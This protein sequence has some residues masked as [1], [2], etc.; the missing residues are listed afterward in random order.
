MIGSVV[1]TI[2]AQICIGLVS[3]VDN[4]YSLIGYLASA[5]IF[6][7]ASIKTFSTRIYTIIGIFMIFKLSFSILTYIVD[8]EKAQK[9]GGKFVM[10]IAISLGLIVLTPWLFAKA[11]QLQSAIL[12]DN[13]IGKIFLGIGTNATSMT[14][15]EN[16]PITY[17]LTYGVGSPFIY[18]ESTECQNAM[19]T[20]AEA[21]AQNCDSS[22]PFTKV[23][24]EKDITYYYDDSYLNLKTDGQYIIH[25]VGWGVLA[26]LSYIAVIIV[27]LGIALDV[28]VRTVKLGFLQIIAPVPIIM[29]MD[30]NKTGKDSMLGKWGT[31]CIN[32]YLDLFARLAALFFGIAVIQMIVQSGIT[33]AGGV[34]E[35]T[36]VIMKLFIIACLILGT[37]FFAKKLPDLIQKIL[38]IEFKGS[39][40]IKQG[41]PRMGRG[42]ALGAFG[43]A[44]GGIGGA[45][46]GIGR[47]IAGK[48]MKGGIEAQR[49]A[50]ARKRELKSNPDTGAFGRFRA[51]ANQMI[52]KPD[53]AA[54]DENTLKGFDRQIAD[55]DSQMGEYKRQK[56]AYESAKGYS[57]KIN[58]K[59]DKWLEGRVNDSNSSD[60]ANYYAA[61]DRYASASAALEKTPTNDAY[62][63][64]KATA[65][66]NT[67]ASEMNATKKAARIQMVNDRQNKL[68]AEIMGF[69]NI[70]SQNG[71]GVNITDGDSIYDSTSGVRTAITNNVN[72]LD[73]YI[74]PIEAQ[75]SSVELQKQQ[76]QTSD[77]YMKNKNDSQ[78]GKK[79]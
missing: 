72:T 59:V 32:T 51:R 66:K 58:D 28:A 73:S 52:G 70:S 77:K 9:T 39:L 8:P 21:V 17:T 4:I 54:R 68:Q 69:N 44:S 33:Y 19:V 15:S 42:L 10:N 27:L 40:G 49:K 2:F 65:A 47:G 43:L 16:V 71:L 13:T 24:D 61:Q 36:G 14:T 55:Y 22:G 57:D 23:Y 46:G 75:K 50:N 34:T 25:F 60:I 35:P 7:V 79:G 62:A 74:M 5:Q 56:S 48:D 3:L 18:P 53:A 63:M 41:I 30:P 11:F 78:Y 38:G 45:L 12:E 76:Y 67:A 37:L 1:R 31:E 6:D 29:Y 20:S 64:A 26:P